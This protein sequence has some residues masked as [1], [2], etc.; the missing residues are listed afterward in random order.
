MLEATGE[1]RKT[2]WKR[3]EEK[4]EG[5][6][7]DLGG[8]RREKVGRQVR[9]DLEEDLREW[10][11]SGFFFFFLEQGGW[12]AKGEEARRSFTGGAQVWSL[13]VP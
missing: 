6:S 8:L 4:K 9:L 11:R 7:T 12:R 5:R 10:R 13:W 2:R 1:R 3:H